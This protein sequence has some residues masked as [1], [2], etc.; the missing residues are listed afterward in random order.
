MAA[1]TVHTGYPRS[2]VNGNYREYLYNVDIAADADTL[3]VPLKIVK[4]VSLTDDTTTAVGIAS[5]V[6]NS[7]GFTSRLTFN[8]AGAINNCFVRVIG[9]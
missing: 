7:D 9:L 2:L 6:L 8:S 5:V 3:D 1:V 4:G